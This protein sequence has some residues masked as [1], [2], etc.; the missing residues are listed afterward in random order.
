M[1]VAPEVLDLLADEAALRVPEHQPGA[2]LVGDREEVQLAA[3]L[4]VVAAL[5]LLEADEVLRPA[6]PC[7]KK[8]YP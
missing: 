3:E 7:V 1:L 6:P 5:G 8:A 4:A 2:R